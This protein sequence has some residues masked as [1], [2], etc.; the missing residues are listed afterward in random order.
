MLPRFTLELG[1]PDGDPVGSLVPFGDTRHYRRRTTVYLL[2][3]PVFQHLR[4]PSAP[5][6]TTFPITGNLL[7]AEPNPNLP[8]YLYT[9]VR[10]PP[11]VVC[12]WL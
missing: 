2:Y 12:L 11:Y 8:V 7:Q 6:P 9:F 3:L 1:L 10:H 5:T 4:L